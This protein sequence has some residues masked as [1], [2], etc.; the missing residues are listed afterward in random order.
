MIKN[1]ADSQGKSLMFFSMYFKIKYPDVVTVAASGYFGYKERF[2]L[3]FILFSSIA[4]F[5]GCL[6]L[7]GLAHVFCIV[8][9]QLHVIIPVGKVRI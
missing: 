1:S 2:S 7:N 3:F 5:V 9:N 4:L 6:D 8:I